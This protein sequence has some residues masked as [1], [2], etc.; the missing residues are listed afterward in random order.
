VQDWIE[1]RRLRAWELLEAGWRQIDIA[2]AL[3][4]TKGAVS[5]WVKR[6]RAGGIEALGRHPAPGASSKLSAEQI[7]QLPQIL[8]CG[9]EAYGFR[10]NVWTHRRIAW[11]IYE[12]F[13]VSY[14]ENHIP[15]ILDKIGWTRQ[16]PKRRATQGN[17]AVIQE[18]KACSWQAIQARADGA[19]QTIVFIDESGFRLLPGMVRTY[20]PR[21]QTPVLDVPLSYEHLSVIGAVTLDGEIFSW[22][23]EHSIKGPDVVRFLKHLLVQLPGR[24]LVVWD[25]LKAHMSQPVKDFLAQG[26]TKRLTLQAL[27]AYA[28]ELNPQEGVWRYLKYVELKNVICH[29][30]SELRLEV[31]RAI[32]RLRDKLE[33]IFG[34]IRQ[35]GYLQ[36]AMGAGANC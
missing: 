35:S 24:I 19:R 17:E 9:A 31:R 29:N 30:L 2:K 18:W 15:R 7:A 36:P 16:K 5:Q 1:G 6:A 4:V 12:A 10:G 11:A 26:G 21:G 3:G 14:H 13:G 27:P 20:A 22:I 25:N 34:C 32:E 23:Y 33:V 28:P 8:S